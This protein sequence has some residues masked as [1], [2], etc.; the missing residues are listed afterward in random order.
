M[1]STTAQRRRYVIHHQGQFLYYL[2]KA[3]FGS[4]DGSIEKLELRADDTPMTCLEASNYK[5]G[6]YAADHRA[7]E[8]LVQDPAKRL[9][10][11][12]VLKDDIVPSEKYP[13]AITV[14]QW[15]AMCG[16]ENQWRYDAEFRDEPAQWVALA[17]DSG[18]WLQ[19]EGTPPPKQTEDSPR[20]I[21]D[22]LPGL[23]ER[24]EFHHL[25]PGRIPGLSQYLGQLLRR[26]LGSF[27]VT[28]D[29]AGRN[30]GIYVR[31]QIPFERAITRWE[32]NI[33][34]SGNRLKSGKT[35]QTM[36]TREMRLPVPLDVPG[37]TYAEALAAWNDAVEYWL[38]VV[39]TSAKGDA[40][41]CNHCASHGF[42]GGD[43][44]TEYDV[45]RDV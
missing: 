18:D 41:A 30:A 31:L 12:Y 40:K 22:L 28:F 16:D 3:D 23:M 39:R 44:Y 14:E 15:R 6:W 29:A 10:A 1:S 11:Q 4:R 43:V 2:D 32:A 5:G 45:P 38:G 13:Q 42:V 20:W 9:I 21:P 8:I 27:Q 35:V 24:P 25:M 37:E 19:I 26:E 33:G 17:V 7:R 34:R 36:V